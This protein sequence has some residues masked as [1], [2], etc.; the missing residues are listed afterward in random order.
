MQQDSNLGKWIREKWR[1]QVAFAEKLG[2]HQGRLSKW[3]GGA[4]GISDDYQAKIRKLGYV[5]PWPSEE[6]KE[7]SAPVGG[8][9]VTV[10]DFAEWRGYWR[11]GTERVL[12]EAEAMKKQIA[13]LARRL[14][15]LEGAK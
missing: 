9:Y 5:G 13:D 12:E 2:V 6:A 4:E 8:P 10:A 11:A 15:R 1:T 3:L 7:A 14:D